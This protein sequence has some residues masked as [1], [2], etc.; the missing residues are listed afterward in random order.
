[1]TALLK[2]RHE[3]NEMSA[4]VLRRRSVWPRDGSCKLVIKVEWF[5][6]PP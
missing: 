4:M 1:V 5:Q 6:N 3:L 2:P